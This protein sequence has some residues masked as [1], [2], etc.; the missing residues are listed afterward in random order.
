MQTF[1]ACSSSSW[2]KHEMTSKNADLSSL[3][4]FGSDGTNG[5]L[6]DL[7]LFVVVQPLE[8]FKSI[9]DHGVDHLGAFEVL[10][11]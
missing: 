1:N 4:T 9:R 3:G 10:K 11:A 2:S 6:A 7:V 5:E 8:S